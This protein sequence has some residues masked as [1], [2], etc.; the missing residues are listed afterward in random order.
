MQGYPHRICTREYSEDMEKELQERVKI[1][2]PKPE[3]FDDSVTCAN[4]P[5]RNKGLCPGDTGNTCASEDEGRMVMFGV[6][7]G[8]LLECGNRFPAIYGILDHRE[9]LPFIWKE[10]F[11][12]EF[13]RFVRPRYDR[14]WY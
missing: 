1:A 7:Q 3:L 10:V 2:L 12:E 9:T 13:K 11:G 8:V 14:Y 6:A 5:S 4:P